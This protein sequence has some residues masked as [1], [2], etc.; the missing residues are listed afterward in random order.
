MRRGFWMGKTSIFTAVK[1]EKLV[2]IFLKLVR[3]KALLQ[4]NFSSIYKILEPRRWH[5]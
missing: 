2:L 3:A 1:Q 4:Y 5:L